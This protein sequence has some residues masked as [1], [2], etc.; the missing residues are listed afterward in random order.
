M[1]KE[2][3]TKSKGSRRREIIKMRAE[4]DKLETE[5]QQRKSMKQK[6]DPLKRSIK[7]TSC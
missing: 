2:E 3:Q 6:T 1:E 7:C 5:N 4:I